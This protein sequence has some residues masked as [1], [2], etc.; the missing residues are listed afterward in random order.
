[1]G[2]ANGILGSPQC[3]SKKIIKEKTVQPDTRHAMISDYAWSMKISIILCKMGIGSHSRSH[4]RSFPVLPIPKLES[5]SHIPMPFSFPLGIQLLRSFLVLIA[6]HYTTDVADQ[7]RRYKL[8]CPN[9]IYTGGV[10]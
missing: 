2:V 6:R 5:Y 8:C 3:S 7:L 9:H 10:H 4:L 1:M